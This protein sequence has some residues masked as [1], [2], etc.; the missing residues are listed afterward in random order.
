MNDRMRRRSASV[1]R[2]HRGDDFIELALRELRIDRQRDDL[3]RRALRLGTT[4]R[5]V[6]QVLETGLKVKRQWIIDGRSD[7]LFLQVGLQSVAAGNAERVLIE[8]RDIARLY[9]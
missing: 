8:D 1:E 6:A 5:L 3:C 4:S 7:A 9:V 2:A